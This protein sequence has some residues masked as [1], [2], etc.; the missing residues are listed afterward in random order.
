MDSDVGHIVALV[1]QLGLDD[2]TYIF[3]T[4]DNGPH[5]EG[6]ADPVYFNSAGPLRG[7]KRDLYEGGI[8][9]P[10]IAWSPKN[11]PAGKVSNTPWAFWDVL[12]TF[13]ELTH[14]KSLP[15]IN[16]LSYVA[17]LKGKKQVNQHDHFYWQFNEKY[18]QEALI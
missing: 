4:R 11:I 16:G 7:V 5:E 17:S 1:K 18:L 3:F 15:D 8:R 2:N 9:V 6:G 12:P 13:S 14:S 10:L